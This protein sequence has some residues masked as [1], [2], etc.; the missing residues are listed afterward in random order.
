MKVARSH[1]EAG[2]GSRTPTD[3]ASEPV[4]EI[5]VSDKRYLPEEELHRSRRYWSGRECAAREK[6][7]A[8]DAE[9]CR[10][11]AHTP[12]VPPERQVER[13]ECADD[14]RRTSMQKFC[15]I[16][17]QPSGWKRT[18]CAD[19]E[20]GVAHASKL[21]QDTYSKSGKPVTL[22]VVEVKQVISIGMPPVVVSEPTPENLPGLVGEVDGEETVT[23]EEDADQCTR[24]AK[25]GFA[26]KRY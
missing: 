18:W 21:V 2:G 9:L 8:Y 12:Y 4:E 26:K 15:V 14:E 1:R 20:A 11:A 5:T 23:A 22:L 17:A 25:A 10:R 7:L 13:G 3:A 16:G 19:Q 6:R 24:V